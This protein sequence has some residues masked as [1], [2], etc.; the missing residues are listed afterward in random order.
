MYDFDGTLR[1]F[2]VK[3]EILVQHLA[4]PIHTEQEISISASDFHINLAIIQHHEWS[5]IEAVGCYRREDN[6]IDMWFEQRATHTQVVS[7]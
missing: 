4:T 2:N 5:D 6:R 1:T 7:C 3:L